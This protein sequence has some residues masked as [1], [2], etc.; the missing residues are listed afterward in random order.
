MAEDRNP[1]LSSL[2]SLTSSICITTE[3]L[4]PLEISTSTYT[5][6]SSDPPETSTSQANHNSQISSLQSSAGTSQDNAYNIR[7]HRRQS[8]L[9]S[10][11]ST[12]TTIAADPRSH[13]YGSQS[14][15]RSDSTHR[16]GSASTVIGGKSA[17][18][19]I[20]IAVFYEEFIVRH[21][22]YSTC[23]TFMVLS[24]LD[25]CDIIQHLT[26]PKTAT[27]Q[28]CHIYNISVRSA[29]I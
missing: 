9:S 8:S 27:Q 18:G 17:D 26:T 28:S 16:S 21:V 6:T 22:P 13:F 4:Q 1:L 29:C 19:V 11:E 3:P 24:R 10:V 7:R 2:D 15:N 14:T 25:C 5:S 20:K 12:E 23:D